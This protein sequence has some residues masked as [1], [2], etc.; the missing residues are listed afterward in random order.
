M[1]LICRIRHRLCKLAVG[2][3]SLAG[4]TGTARLGEESQ[5]MNS[6]LRKGAIAFVAIAAVAYQVYSQT[7]VAQKKAVIVEPNPDAI[8]E[9]QT[10]RAVPATRPEQKRNLHDES[11]IFSGDKGPPSSPVLE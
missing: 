1:R 4:R 9:A 8:A 3:R 6:H 2:L 11:G 5:V 7:G 10:P